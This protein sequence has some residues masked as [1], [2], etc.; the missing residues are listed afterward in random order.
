LGEF[1]SSGDSLCV[2]VS[3]KDQSLISFVKGPISILSEAAF[4]SDGIGAAV[5]AE[6]VLIVIRKDIDPNGAEGHVLIRIGR[7]TTEDDLSS[8]FAFR[9]RSL[10][11]VSLSL[12]EVLDISFASST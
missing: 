12:I 6:G 5:D 10:R 4:P 2:T 3:C 8:E 7:V 9:L 11:G 1:F